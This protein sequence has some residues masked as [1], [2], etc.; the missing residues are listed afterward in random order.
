MAESLIDVFTLQAQALFGT[1]ATAEFLRLLRE[2]GRLC[3]T[4]CAACGRIAYPPR[5][6]CP[7]CRGRS[8]EWVPIGEGATLYAFTTQGRAL[9]FSAPEVL[10]LVD[11][12]DVGRILS[13]IGAPYAECRIGMALRFEPLPVAEGL[14]LHRFVPA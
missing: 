6:H 3:S 1:E 13:L 5:G 10:G 4:R 9:R 2:E 8:V 11:L 14:V 7:A 12:P